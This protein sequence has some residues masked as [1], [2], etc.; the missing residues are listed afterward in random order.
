MSVTG[1]IHTGISVQDLERSIAFYV[2]HFG[3]T[4]RQR[5][6]VPDAYIGVI[7][8]Y[9]GVEMHQAF[10]DIPN[11]SHW[12]ELNEYRNIERGS[13]DPASGN[14]GTVH[15]CVKVDDLMGMYERMSAAGVE[16][17]NPPIEPTAGP[18]VGGLVVYLKDPD[19]VR[20]ELIQTPA[21]STW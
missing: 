15:L 18:N 21:G 8:G 5:R 12:L 6:V 16:F 1:S 19:G 2:D 3:F 13:I 17:V 14:V 11:S 7:T 9:P 10:L 4:V 20:I